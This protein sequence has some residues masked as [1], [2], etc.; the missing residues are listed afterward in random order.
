MSP[1]Q[2]RGE[3]RAVTTAAD[4]YGL[5]AVFYETLAG[6]PPFGG[7][8]SLET[9]RQVLD[10]E[11]RRP[12]VFNPEV[13]RD[14]ETICLK[15]LEKEPAR[16]YGSA[17]ALADDLERWLRRN[18]SILARPV[19][20]LTRVENWVRR[21][22]ALAGALATALLLLL[23]VAI[24]SPI[25]VL[26]ISAARSESEKNLYVANIH[27]ANEALEVHDLAQTRLLLREIEKSSVQRA[28]HGWEWRYLAGRSRGDELTTLYHHEAPLP[29]LAASPN[30]KWLAAI[31]EDGE[32]K[33]W[34]FDSRKEI[35]SWSAHTSVWNSRPAI[36]QAQLG[37][38]TR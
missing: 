27:L 4:V 28:M 18:Q 33:L 5:G 15:C 22:P 19:S 25:A 20:A 29:G 38:C 30:G 10:E 36:L 13:D 35:N 8:T 23:I 37:L 12:S 21:K 17:E 2:A 6:T 3:N 11:P 16:R 32:V 1:E 14:L 24:G 31:G 34:D 26:R 7:G 9:I